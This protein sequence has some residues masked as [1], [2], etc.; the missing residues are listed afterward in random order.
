MAAFEKSKAAVFI[1]IGDDKT[2]LQRLDTARP[3]AKINLC[4]IQCRHHKSCGAKCVCTFILQQKR[5]VPLG[6]RKKLIN[7]T[8]IP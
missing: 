4:K 6:R 8:D 7:H 3:Y 5:G 2:H 1:F